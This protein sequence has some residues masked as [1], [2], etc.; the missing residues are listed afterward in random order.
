MLQRSKPLA[1]LLLAVAASSACERNGTPTTSTS[2]TPPTA[3]TRGEPDI[4][5]DEGRLTA[6]ELD[7]GRTDP[8]WRR[9]VLFDTVTE[10]GET[11]AFE[12]AWDEISVQ[13]VNA[14]AMH[15][16]LGD[17][18]GPSVLR[19]QI[20]LDRAYFSPGIIDGR[21]GAN[22][23]KAVYWFQHREGLPATG[24]LDRRTFARLSQRAGNP[25]ELIERYTLSPE[26]VEGPFI[27]IPES[28][29]EQAEL[30]C[31][32]YQSL[33]EKL[34]ER[35]HTS[36]ELLGRLNPEAALGE[37]RAGQALFVPAVRD[38]AAFQGPLVARIVISDEGRYLHAL[39]AAGRLVF[40][41]PSTL[42]SQYS[43]SPTG[44]FRVTSVTEEPWWHY[45]PALLPTVDD[46]E[47]DARIP[48]GPNNAVGMVWMA[49]SK[50]HYGIHGTD[51]PETIGTAVSAGCV[52]LTNWDAVFLSRRLA[53]G[54]PVE[55]RDTEGGGA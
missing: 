35:F 23:E 34:A 39:D 55:F 51:S 26:D 43:P 22:T 54:T 1:A 36:P 48:P 3:E 24:R 15:L 37:A 8:S 50:P 40:H 14:G 18:S 20:L 6:E 16:P 2:D 12:E 52:R 41:F 11:N 47:P 21:W 38:T 27:D 17:G 9:V 33:E 19:A 45:Q 28:R 13:R 32:C 46:D 42:G 7:R 53:D 10:N 4:F 49:L 5:W 29:Y 30:E 44:D 31:M 25:T